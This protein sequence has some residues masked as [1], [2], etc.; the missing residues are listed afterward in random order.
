M[1]LKYTD[2]NGMEHDNIV[3]YGSDITKVRCR[4]VEVVGVWGGK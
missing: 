4:E 1:P 3:V 2:E